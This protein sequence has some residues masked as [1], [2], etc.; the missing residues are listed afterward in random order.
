MG[1]AYLSLGSNVAPEHHLRVAIDALRARFGQVLLS[2]V[3]R[4]RSVGFDGTDFLNAAAV[5]ES[6]LD[7]FALNDWL[8]ALEDAHGRDRSGPRF[9]DRT[10]DIDIVFYDD[11]VLQGPGNLRLPRDE[12]KHAFVLLPLADIAPDKI[13]PRSSMTLRALWD[14][15]PDRT[16][17]PEA[18]A[19][20]AG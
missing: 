5:I 8:H 17:P 11:L 4:T 13:D 19:I 10:L 3:Y 18:V 14:A 16:S 15:H 9:S 20:D 1:L 7:P 12:L 6:D 2:P